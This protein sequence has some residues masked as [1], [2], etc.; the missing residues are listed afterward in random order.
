MK[1]KLYPNNHPIKWGFT[2]FFLAA[3]LIGLE[4]ALKNEESDAKSLES[5]LLSL[6]EKINSAEI[7]RDYLMR[8]IN[9][10]SDPAWIEMVLKK[11]LGLV[12]EGQIKV[13][14]TTDT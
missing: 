7:H 1:K 12:P 2:F 10:Q 14:F 8:Q 6:K 4:L 9:S 13:Y 3:T 5:Q 11:E